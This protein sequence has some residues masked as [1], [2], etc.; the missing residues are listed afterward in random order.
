MSKDLY[1]T[2]TK[3]LDLYN[4]KGN[5]AEGIDFREELHDILWTTDRGSDII[6]R[7][8]KMEN[9][10]PKRCECRK[11]HRSEEPNRDIPCDN[12]SG[13]GFYYNDIPTRTFINHSQAYTIYKKFKADGTT[14]VEYKTS[15]FEWDFIK[16]ALDDGDNIPNRFDTIIQLKKDLTGKVFSPSTPREMYEILSVDPYR[17]DN[18]GRIEYYRIR[19]ISVIDKSFLV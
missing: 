14:N 7:R 19:I 3:T 6:Y 15:Y 17:L 9:G 10:H 13:T 16:N 5:S 18:N 11:G 1:N 12:C 8:V 2:S 4:N